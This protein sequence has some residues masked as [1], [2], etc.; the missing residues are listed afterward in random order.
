MRADRQR[1]V[2][3]IENLVRN[4]LDALGTKNFNGEAPTIWIEG[5]VTKDG[6]VLIVRD[7]GPGIKPQDLAR[8][9]DPFFTTK[10]VGKGMGLGLTVCQG[11]VQA[12]GGNII[13]RSEPGKYCEFLLEFRGKE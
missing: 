3:V 5:R 2:Q 13:A 8:V 1:L 10:D 7:N 9:F 4:S 11:I 12:C 6:S